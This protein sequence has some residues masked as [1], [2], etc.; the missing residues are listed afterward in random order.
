MTE[1][2]ND[3]HQPPRVDRF[4]DA[5]TVG[6]LAALICLIITIISLCLM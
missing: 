5:M 4:D 1:Y 6:I 2:H 3:W